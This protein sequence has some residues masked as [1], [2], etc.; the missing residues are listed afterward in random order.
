MGKPTEEE[1][2][3]ALAVAKY[4][5]ESGQDPYCLAKAL[6]NL[7]YRVGY[8]EQVMQAAVSY[9]RSGLAER[10]HTR[11]VHAIEAVKRVEARDQSDD[12][13]AAGV[14]GLG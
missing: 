12:G 4:M 9:L 8:L 7:N 11:L 2:Q 6:L 14:L 5:R 3:Q 1:L 10:E 13:A